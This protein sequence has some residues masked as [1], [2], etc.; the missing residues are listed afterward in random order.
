[1]IYILGVIWILSKCLL[2][3]TSLETEQ[4]NRPI[5]QICETLDTEVIAA[6]AT[7]SCSKTRAEACF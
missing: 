3:N 5:L 4:E 6:L 2:G 1:M 7:I